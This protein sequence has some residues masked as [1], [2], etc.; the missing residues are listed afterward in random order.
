MKSIKNIYLFFTILLLSFT[1]LKA[2][3]DSINEI[4]NSLYGQ[5]IDKFQVPIEWNI[6]ISE[7]STN[8][9][10]LLSNENGAYESWVEIVNYGDKPIDINGLY[11]SD[12]FNK[13]SKWQIDN[14]GNAELTTID[15]QSY[16][17]LW[18]DGNSNNS[19]LHLGFI[20][21]EDSR[22]LIISNDSLSVIDKVS[23][24]AIPEDKSFGLQAKMG[25]YNYFDTPTPEFANNMETIFEV[26][27]VPVPSVIGGYYNTPQQISLSSSVNSAA[28]YYTLDGS[29]PN[30]NSSIYNSPISIS[31]TKV[32]R[33]IAYKDGYIPSPITTHSYLF[34]T[35]TNFAT[36][37]LVTEESN[38]TGPNG[39]NE[40]SNRSNGIEKPVHIE[41]FESEGTRVLALNAGM[42]IH[43]PDSRPQQSLRLY[44][45]S[46]YG[47]SKMAH[48]IFPDKEINTFKRI[49]LRNGGNDGAQLGGTHFRDALVHDIFRE[50]SSENIYASYRPAHVFIN[51]NYWGIYNVRER[52]DKH[53]IKSNFG[54]TDIDLLERSA[55]APETRD[56]WAGDWEAY[57]AMENYLYENDMSL[58]ENDDYAQ[59]NIDFD[60]AI[61]YYLTEIYT[62]NRDW[63]TNN[64]KFWKKRTGG[65]WRWILWDTE[66]GMG[67]SPTA[68]HGLP[69]F[70]SLVMVV[71]WG[72][73]DLS[74]ANYGKNTKFMR[75]MIGYEGHVT[76]NVTIEAAEGHP[77][78]KQ[79]F[80]SRSADLLNTYQR[81]S[82]MSAKIDVFKASLTP[83]INR[84]FEKWGGTM[85]EWED[86][87][88]ALRAYTAQRPHYVR[89]NT[90]DRFNLDSEYILDLNVN[91]PNSGQI[92][93]NTIRPEEYPWDGYYFSQIPVHITAQAKPG[94]QFVSWN[95]GSYTNPT[96]IFTADDTQ[97]YTANFE[98]IDAD[99][100]VVINEIN[101]NSNYNFDTGD[102]I[103]IYNPTTETIDL[104]LW[105]F[106]D[107]NSNN[108]Y[109]FP[110]GT[111]INSGAYLVLC[112]DQLKFESLYPELTNVIGDFSFDLNDVGEW[113][114]L[115]DHEGV[116][117]D[118]LVYGVDA[119]WSE[120]P[121]GQGPTLELIQ[122]TWD[123]E[124]AESWQASYT[125][126]G[127][128]GAINSDI[129]QQAYLSVFDPRSI[130]LSQNFPN[131]FSY[132]TTIRCQL[133]SAGHIDLKIY[134]SIGQEVYEWNQY[135]DQAGIVDVL[136][137]PEHLKSGFYY[138]H[139]KTKDDYDVKKM[140]YIK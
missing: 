99:V 66:Y 11:I 130:D 9:K 132:S 35:P 101:Y 20:L 3:S 136:W 107:S 41:F 36:I 134:N 17:L 1:G 15:P 2:Q 105:S 88:E 140:L 124:L 49:V 7:L 131:P 70:N 122:P 64:I 46:E 26:L 138:Y 114:G 52:Q 104:S 56:T 44:A 12:D 63:I 57:D 90:L 69:N 109:V 106:T 42:K 8:N 111:L 67:N 97:S 40:I 127:T 62:G 98:L 119:P 82:Y 55:N 85:E 71:S 79:K 123:N 22:E 133:K 47:T 116:V 33:C 21:N 6:K 13:P 117:V 61:D 4:T 110:D 73:W 53:F 96:H 39:I 24:D 65:K 94:Y 50:Q 72:G 38:W 100:S 45:R 128:P 112:K 16:L 129:S 139:I 27:P 83:E 81:E 135:Y 34:E 74:N 86:K 32:L 89:V 102:W 14:R 137:V 68:S 92:K 29:E 43:A 125:Q 87:I 120:T 78:F 77:L 118:Q 115:Y 108:D 121:N 54:E 95:T 18:A 126:H 84:Q 28:I 51:G 80:I 60:N 19:P 30:Q 48:Q 75:H 113:I 58:P 103:E 10:Q 31:S 5:Q 23:F 37:S 25:V 93:L 91:P 59:Q 76:E